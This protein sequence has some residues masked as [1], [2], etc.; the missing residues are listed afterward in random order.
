VTW[1]IKPYPQDV[2]RLLRLGYSRDNEQYHLKAGLV[3]LHFSSFGISIRALFITP[4][5]RICQIRNGR[6]LRRIET[7]RRFN[8]MSR[9]IELSI[10]SPTRFPFSSQR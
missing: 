2:P 3:E 8:V 1:T 5:E 10:T 7:E 9:E 4:N 6:G